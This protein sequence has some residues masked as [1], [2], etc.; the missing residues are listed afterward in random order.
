M[1]P[2]SLHSG[3]WNEQ[4]SGRH[5]LSHKG[6]VIHLSRD[7]ILTV[8]LEYHY[9]TRGFL[10]QCGKTLGFSELVFVLPCSLWNV[11]LPLGDDLCIPFRFLKISLPVSSTRCCELKQMRSITSCASLELY[12]NTL[13]S[14]NGRDISRLS[15]IFGGRLKYRLQV[16]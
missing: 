11:T 4:A 5:R 13:C 7:R 9:D 8:F 15:H 2:S 10:N 6:A 16:Q 3:E 14:L 1:N 12:R